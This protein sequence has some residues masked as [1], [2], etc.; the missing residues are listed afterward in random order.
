[1][2]G[3]YLPAALLA[4]A[5]AWIG[6]SPAAQADIRVF[7]CE[8]E[9]ASLAEE[10]GGAHV[11]AYA[12]THAEQDVHRIRAKPSLIAALR[13]A[14]MLF[15]SGAELEVGWL[16]IL[17]RRGGGKDLQPGAPG[18]LMAADHVALLDVPEILDRSLGDIH[19][20]GNPHVHLD[21]HNIALLAR[22]AADRLTL[23]DPE[24]AGTYRAQLESFLTRWKEAAA[25][26]SA[27]AERLRGLEVVVHHEAW[28]YLLH[29]AGMK[30][31]ASLERVP[32]VPP[33]LGHLA[34]VLARVRNGDVKAI[35]SAPHEPEDAAAWLSAESGIP[36]VKLPFTVNEEAGVDDLFALFDTTLA[37]LE[38]ARDRR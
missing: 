38:E 19:A 6:P 11:E 25:D 32:G 1:M 16:P 33:S 15:C 27:R 17:L 21:P 8:P 24:N 5:L 13:R 35:L 31:T 36:V 3:R 23:I 10:V 34:D 22:V 14:D 12:A 20:S 37:L 30:Q 9:W 26:W 4:A 18:H 29:W 2:I 7:A 28:S